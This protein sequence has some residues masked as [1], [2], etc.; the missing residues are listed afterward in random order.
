MLTVTKYEAGY[1]LG[2]KLQCTH[3]ENIIHASTMLQQLGVKRKH[4]VNKTGL[5]HLINIRFNATRCNYEFHFSNLH[6]KRTYLY[7]KGNVACSVKNIIPSLCDK[8]II[9]LLPSKANIFEIRRNIS[10][11]GFSS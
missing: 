9:V 6:L 7:A 1:N 10:S 3:V 5:Y 8:C 2:I 11:N 4:N